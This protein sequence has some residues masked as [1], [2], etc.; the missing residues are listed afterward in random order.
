MEG[1]NIQSINTNEDVEVSYTP[2]DSVFRYS[3][4]VIKDNVEAISK[5]EIKAVLDA[6]Q[7]KDSLALLDET[8]KRIFSNNAEVSYDQF[9]YLF[10]SGND[11]S[12][13]GYILTPEGI[14]KYQE[15]YNA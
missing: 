10:T 8:L 5:M 15:I 7:L 6:C 14:R 9:K 3:Y 4:V 13:I 2:S 12:G 1:F 11:Q